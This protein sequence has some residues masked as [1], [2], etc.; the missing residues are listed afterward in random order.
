MAYHL[1]NS[2]RLPNSTHTSQPWRIHTIVPDFILEDVWTIP[3]RGD[4][5]DFKKLVEAW[6][7]LDITTSRSRPLR[8]LWGARDFLGRRFG[9]G[10]IIVPRNTKQGYTPPVLPIPDDTQ[11]SLSTRLPDD[12]RN[13]ITDPYHR[14][15]PLIPLYYTNDEF[16]A[17]L[18]N[19][20]VHAVMHLSWTKQGSGSGNYQGQMAVYVKPRGLLGKIYMALIKPIRLWIVYPILMREIQY[21]WNSPKTTNVLL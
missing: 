17:E 19:K 7:L 15:A 8:F 5:K 16:A 13:T 3:V 20:T 10:R 21:A 9:L 12:L 11:T 18:S 2:I 4:A 14:F 6:S 1:H